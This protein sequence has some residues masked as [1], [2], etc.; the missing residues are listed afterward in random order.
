[1]TNIQTDRQTDGLRNRQTDD[2]TYRWNGQA[3]KTEQHDRYTY[4]QT[5]R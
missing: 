4:R 2:Q 3:D 5:Y 1:L